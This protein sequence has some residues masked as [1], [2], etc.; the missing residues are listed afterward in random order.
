M[1]SVLP[2]S[3]QDINDQLQ[4]ILEFPVFKNSPTLARFLEFIVSETIHER[5]QQIKEYSIAMHVLN[6]SRDFNPTNDAIVRIHA[7]RLRRALH[8][9]YLTD[10]LND[11]IIIHVPKGCYVPEYETIV[12]THPNEATSTF[13]GTAAVKPSIAVFPFRTIPKR[14]NSDVFSL[15]LGEELSAEL[16][17]FRDISVIGYYSME[18]MAKIEQNILEAGRSVGA[19]YIIT[20][21]LQY[22]DQSVRVRA[23]LLVTSTGQVMMT[24]SLGKDAPLPDVFE[25][26]QEIVQ[27]V[28]ASF[29]GSFGNIAVFP[30]PDLA[31]R[32]IE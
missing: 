9:Y 29:E 2:L 18:M 19:D 15:I 14:P 8:E 17:R 31:P 5:N 32:R 23:T 11:P 10:G 21:R 24:K 6:R 26:Q 12:R 16:S 28:V 20:G 25:I 22:N 1:G 27:G 3:A 30:G 13:I 7:G 4:R